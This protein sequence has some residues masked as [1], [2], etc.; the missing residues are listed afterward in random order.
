MIH[1]DNAM[2]DCCGRMAQPGD[3]FKVF[4]IPEVSTKEYAKLKVPAPLCCCPGCKPKVARAM[5][6]MIDGVV[7]VDYAKLLPGLEGGKL[8][9]F[10]RMLILKKKSG[11]ILLKS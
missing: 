7:I 10:L 2:C 8:K 6:R 4:S 5:T 1:G 9:T 11:I 3:D